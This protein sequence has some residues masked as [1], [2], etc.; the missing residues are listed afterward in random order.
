MSDELK[1]IIEQ[2]EQLLKMLSDIR[3]DLRIF[4]EFVLEVTPQ[5]ARTEIE[6]LQ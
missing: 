4:R 5:D 6:S 3:D 2:N 1:T